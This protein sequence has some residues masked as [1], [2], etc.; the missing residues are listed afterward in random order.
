MA[1]G[2]IDIGGTTIKLG[3]WQEQQIIAK[4]SQPTPDNLADFYMLLT[5]WVQQMRQQFDLTGIGIS[6]PGA[7][8]QPAGIIRGA[9]AISY[10]HNFKIVPEL[11]QRFGLPVAIEND[12]NCAALAEVTAGIA[13]G[14][15]DVVFLV[16]G[17]G[18][19]GAIIING[20]VRHGQHL[21]GGEFGYM[22]TTDTATVSEAGTA[23]KMAQYYNQSHH[24]TLTGQEIFDLAGTGDKDAQQ[25]LQ[26]LYHV[27]AKMIFNLQYSIY[28]QCFV[29]G[30]GISANP[31]LL[32][33]IEKAVDQIM[34][35]VSIATVRPDVRL[36]Q[37]RAEANLRG[38]A[39]NYWQ[40]R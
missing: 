31:A 26:Q 13:Q 10:I 27:L 36:C 8:D 2:L 34:N 30:G 23:V 35:Q 37:F 33:G 19:G 12:A 29:I 40:Q 9:S 17:T 28:P 25:A 24:T 18:V 16:I 3:I 5:Q 39:V 15:Q 38:A 4:S 21:L 14:L 1:L 6:S 32:P 11:E 22:L 7:V 20:Q